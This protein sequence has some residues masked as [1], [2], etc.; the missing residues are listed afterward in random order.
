AEMQTLMKAWADG[1]NYFLATHPQVKPR[2]L[3]RFEPWMVMS[4]TEGS[5]GGDIERI[6][7]DA[8]REF[9]AGGLEKRLSLPESD[10]EKQASNGI[11]IAPPLTRARHALL[12]SNAH[13]S[14]YFRSEAQVTSDEG[15]NA[16]GASTWGQFFIYQG[17]NAHAGWLHTSSGTDNV[18]EFTEVVEQRGQKRCYRYGAS[19]N[20]LGIR[21]VTIR[22]RLPSGKLGSRRFTPYFT[23]PRPTTRAA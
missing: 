17:F 2:V 4:F 18:D 13:T 16:Y 19:C 20:P 6:K 10:P 22:Y 5:I 3:R 12:L 11:A 21:S 7:L 14:F 1:L 9:Y 8:L 15:L 23:P